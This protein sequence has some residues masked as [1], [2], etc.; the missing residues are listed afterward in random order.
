MCGIVAALEHVPP[1]VIV[2]VLGEV[3]DFMAMSYAAPREAEDQAS[4]IDFRDTTARATAVCRLSSSPPSY[5]ELGA[6]ECDPSPESV[7][8]LNR[9]WFVFHKQEYN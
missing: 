2:G 9:Q 8:R 4:P 7:A 6:G 5:R 1:D 3:V